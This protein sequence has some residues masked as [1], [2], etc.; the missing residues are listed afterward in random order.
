MSLRRLAGGAVPPRARRAAAAA[1]RRDRAVWDDLRRLDARAARLGAY[2]SLRQA[3]GELRAWFAAARGPDGPPPG[4]DV[5]ARLLLRRWRVGD[6]GGSFDGVE[7][8]ARR[9]GLRLRAATGARPSDADVFARVHDGLHRAFAAALGRCGGLARTTP[10]LGR[11]RMP[12]RALCAAA[13]GEVAHVAAALALAPAAPASGPASLADSLPPQ[14]LEPPSPDKAARAAPPS[15]SPRRRRPGRTRRRPSR[16]GRRRRSTTGRGRRRRPRPNR[17]RAGRARAAAPP[18]PGDL[19]RGGGRPRDRPGRRGQ[20]SGAAVAGAARR[21]GRRAPPCDRRPRR[22][23]RGNRSGSAVAGCHASAGARAAGEAVAL[24][25]AIGAAPQTAPA[26]TAAERK[27][28]RSP[29]PPV[30]VEP[31]APADRPAGTGT[32]A[33]GDADDAAAA[34]RHGPREGGGPRRDAAG[35][36]DARGERARRRRRREPPALRRGAAR[37]ADRRA[38]ERAQGLHR[39]S[40]SGCARWRRRRARSARARSGRP[41]SSTA[42]RGT[43]AARRR[44]AAA[45]KPSPTRRS[46]WPRSRRR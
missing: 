39:T 4:R 32:D 25:V 9:A 8:L 14:Q 38:H 3:H 1:D 26:P 6:Q 27:R 20:R 36:V 43:A 2:A 11:G 34:A 42:S 10:A 46:A 5:E 28:A 30:V 22:P 18:P 24:P 13:Q 33:A 40:R 35:A 45:S 12:V 16:R 23:R 17:R 19:G 29:P 31:V 7:S 44:A 37:R 41:S 21:R 15:P